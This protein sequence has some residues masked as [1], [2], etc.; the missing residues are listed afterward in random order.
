MQKT[1]LYDQHVNAGAQMVPF[2]GW[3]M[4]L[5]YGSQIEEHQVVRESAGVFDVSHM[6]TTHC[7]GEQAQAFLRYVLANDVA[8]LKAPGRALYTCMLNE[9]AGILDDLIVYY[10]APDHY[11]LV[12]NAATREKDL[13]W[14]NKQAQ[15]FQ[16]TLEEDTS[17][18]LLAIQG[19]LARE[20]T[21]AV[22]PE[23]LQPVVMDLKPFTSL[24]GAGFFVGR[25]GYTGEDGF[26]VYA[27]KDQV[28]D[29]WEALLRQGVKPIG[30][31]ARDS[32]RL[33]AGLN[34]YGNDMDEG[35]TPYESNVGWTV[36]LNPPEREFIGREAL[37]LS[38]ESVSLA[39]TGV[40]LPSRGML[41]TGM[42]VYAGDRSIG[43]I[44]SAV[45]S[46]TLKHSIAM[47]RVQAGH[48]GEWSV[49]LRGKRCPIQAVPLPFVK[50]GAPTFSLP[51]GAKI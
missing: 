23:S 17:G 42:E 37:E 13:A 40:V 34:L 39:L 30:L 35:V 3:Q 38:R 25:T 14:L 19:P 51:L 26:E 20:R 28:Q 46:P 21:Q 49:D 24:S 31:G 7:R 44:T 50:Q 1:A 36:A 6:V 48:T 27:P 45:Y 33:E 41:R 2:A 4:P 11:R 15:D 16:V 5:H 29:F 22:L 47:A 32:L 9:S 18:V 8:K 43:T 12:T 10:H